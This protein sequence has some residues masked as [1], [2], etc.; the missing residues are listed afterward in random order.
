MIIVCLLRRDNANL[1]GELK[2]KTP[3]EILNS[4]VEIIAKPINGGVEVSAK[5]INGE[6]LTLIPKSKR[7]PAVASI[8]DSRANGNSPSGCAGM[9][10]TF[11][12]SVKNPMY[13]RA[14]LLKTFTVS[15]K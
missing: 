10:F 11:S 2:M 7:K 14:N 13:P 3:D 5:L 8:F 9:Y 6:L 12:K 15:Y 4:I 1:I